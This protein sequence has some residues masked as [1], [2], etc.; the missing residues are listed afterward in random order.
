MFGG[1]PNA[2]VMN[3]SLYGVW[4]R[5]GWKTVAA[6]SLILTFD[7][8]TGVLTGFLRT[9]SRVEFADDFNSYTGTHS[10]EV[11][12]CTSPLACPDPLDPGAPRR[13]QADGG[14]ASDAY[15][16]VFWN[17]ATASAMITTV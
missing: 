10:F 17:R 9:H 6:T 16:V 8:A 2:T 4:Q 13:D 12:T 15:A 7:R 3:S 5:T 1:V 14:R 11:L